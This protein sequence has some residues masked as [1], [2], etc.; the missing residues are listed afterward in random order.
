VTT[1]TTAAVTTATVTTATTMTLR[2]RRTSK[3]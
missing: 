3:S 1:A 2:H